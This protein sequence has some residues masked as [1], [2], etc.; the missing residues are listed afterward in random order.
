MVDNLQNEST[1]NL[2]EQ[3]PLSLVG[4]SCQASITSA[5]KGAIIVSLNIGQHNFK[6]VLL[7]TT[8]EYVLYCTCTVLLF[9]LYIYIHIYHIIIN[10]N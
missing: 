10:V 4:S 7:E 5:T 2:D 1:G 6:G 3:F 8:A 9:I